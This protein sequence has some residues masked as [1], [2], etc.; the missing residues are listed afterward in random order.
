M[1]EG[2]IFP[3]PINLNN[4]IP[5]NSDKQVDSKSLWIYIKKTKK[6]F[7]VVHSTKNT[8]KSKENIFKY[9]C[10]ACLLVNEN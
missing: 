5:N 6:K 9:K 1:S 2:W 10:C 7:S 4:V 3:H 8:Y